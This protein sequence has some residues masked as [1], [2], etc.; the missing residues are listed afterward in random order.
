M[1]KGGKAFISLKLSFG[2]VLYFFETPNLEEASGG[3][4]AHSPR[5]LRGGPAVAPGD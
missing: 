2:K 1:P 4:V 5:Q 3:E